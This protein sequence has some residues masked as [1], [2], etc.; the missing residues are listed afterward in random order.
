[1]QQHLAYAC[2]AK[3][4]TAIGGKGDQK[5]RVRG[6]AHKKRRHPERSAS[7]RKRRCAQSKG[8]CALLVSGSVLRLRAAGTAGA[9]LISAAAL[10]SGCFRRWMRDLVSEQQR[11]HRTAARP[12]RR[13]ERS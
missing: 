1:M 8:A 7:A 3:F 5:R 4:R 2:H 13:S 10:R 9:K 11:A 12:A 6:S